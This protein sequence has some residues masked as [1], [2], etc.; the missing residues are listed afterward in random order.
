MSN[1]GTFVNV[2]ACSPVGDQFAA[3]APAS[4]AYYTD[5]S[6]VHGCTPARSPLPM[7]SIHGGNDGSVAY[8]G[9]DGSGGPLPAIPDWLGWWAER[10]GCTD[11]KTDDSFDGDVH[12]SSWTCGDGVEALLQHWKVDSMGKLVSRDGF[13]T[14]DLA[15]IERRTLL[16]FYRNQLL[17]DRGRGGPDSYPG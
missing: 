4:G 6:G 3:F 9:G 2:I 15:D 5:N 14:L 8:G 1:G 7:L 11:E 17:A 13:I 10:S 16:G 12:H